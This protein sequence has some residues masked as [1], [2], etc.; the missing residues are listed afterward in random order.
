MEALV[1]KH[2]DTYFPYIQDARIFRQDKADAL[3]GR[4]AISCP[5]FDYAMFERCVSYALD[6][7]WGKTQKF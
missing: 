5:T 4:R 1:E 3:L 6:T 2:L 7:D